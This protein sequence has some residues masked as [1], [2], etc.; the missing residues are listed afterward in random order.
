VTSAGAQGQH[1][2]TSHHR[3][4]GPNPAIIITHDAGS[5][6]APTSDDPAGTVS[7]GQS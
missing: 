6:A 1:F 7:V 3:A 2:S 4:D 5:G